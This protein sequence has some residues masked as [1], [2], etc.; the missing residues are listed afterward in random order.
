[1]VT[2]KQGK[3]LAS[4][5]NSFQ[6]SCDMATRALDEGNNE[7]YRRWTDNADIV[8]LVLNNHFNITLPTLEDSLKSQ[9]GLYG[10][11]KTQW[12]IENMYQ[13]VVDYCNKA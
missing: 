8:S 7:G 5:I 12:R 11:E 9:L 10:V 1:M 6:V 4:L 13:D 3:Q 2:V